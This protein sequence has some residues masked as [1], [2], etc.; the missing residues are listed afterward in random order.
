MKYT[1]TMIG[2]GAMAPSGAPPQARV[3]RDGSSFEA[4]ATTDQLAIKT[5]TGELPTIDWN[6]EVVVKVEGLEVADITLPAVHGL[7]RDGDRVTLD[8][9]FVNQNLDVVMGPS[10]PWL[11]ARAP[12]DAFA[13]DP[14]IVLV[15]NGQRF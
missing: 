1:A 13:G 8:V 2:H 7:E 3:F 10:R 12:A 6:G 4:A 14:E 9:E 5:S 11:Y 15:V